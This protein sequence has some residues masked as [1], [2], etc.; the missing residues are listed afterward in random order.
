MSKVLQIVEHVVV[1]FFE[2][3]LAYYVAVGSPQISKA[4]VVGA[5]GAGISAVYNILRQ[6]TPPQSTPPAVTQPPVVPPVPPVV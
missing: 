1:T 3:V 4:L 6:S 5:I 2:A